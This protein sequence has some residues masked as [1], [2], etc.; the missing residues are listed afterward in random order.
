MKKIILSLAFTAVVVCF[1]S[2]LTL[3][4]C[5][6]KTKEKI[7]DAR[8]AIGQEVTTSM[9]SVQMKAEARMDSLKQK[10]NA[11]VDSIKIRSAEKMQE[12]AQKLKESVKK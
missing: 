5:Q 3:V 6:E 12:A 9:D 1:A 8:D 7:E 11:K 4:S 10:A 2:S